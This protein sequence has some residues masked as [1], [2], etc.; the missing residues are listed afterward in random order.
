MK[1]DYK[2]TFYM[3]NKENF[4]IYFFGTSKEE[5]TNH[6]SGCI[7]CSTENFMGNKTMEDFINVNEINYFHIEELND[8]EENK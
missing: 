2:V 7:L 3:K 4:T 5:I 6:M 1:K 8:K